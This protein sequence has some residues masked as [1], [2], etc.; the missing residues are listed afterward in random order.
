M[1]PWRRRGDD[2]VVKVTIFSADMGIEIVTRWRII[3][4]EL[5]VEYETSFT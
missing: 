4:T 5:N 2:A 1:A 3:I